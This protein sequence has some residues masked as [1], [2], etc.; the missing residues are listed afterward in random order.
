MSK[1]G[2]RRNYGY[3]KTLAWAGKNALKDRY[4]QGHFATQAAHAARWKQFATFAKSAG[5]KDARDITT[6]SIETYGSMLGRQVASKAMSVRYA[7]NLLS[8]VNVVLETM[9]GDRRVRISPASMAGQRVNVRQKA[10]VSLDR[11]VH[12]ERIAALVAKNE[13]AVALVAA[14]ARDLGVRFREASLLNCGQALKE[15]C[16]KAHISIT[17]GTKGGRGKEFSRSVPVSPL[18]LAT[19]QRA[20]QLQGTEQN[21]LP[22]G[23][24]FRAWRDHAYGVWR[25]TAH[26]AERFSF[27]DLRAAYAC[28][29]YQ[30]LTGSPAPVVAGERL[31]HRAADRAARSEIA[32]ELGHGRIDVMAAYVGSSK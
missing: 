16:D 18:A 25:R 13:H 11:R 29:R 2:G 3:G 19:L 17:R 30:A 32:L 5:T 28:E 20:S 27:H 9:R 23:M 26:R 22:K 31:V 6:E 21:L 7:Q 8:T 14:L 12:T 4:G 24:N 1:V 15:A 10:A